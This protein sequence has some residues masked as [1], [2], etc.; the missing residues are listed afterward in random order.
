MNK[1][2]AKA[3]VKAKVKKTN[4]SPVRKNK[5]KEFKDLVAYR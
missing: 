2:K 5:K 4:R 3:K 1:V